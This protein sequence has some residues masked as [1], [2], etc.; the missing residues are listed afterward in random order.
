MANMGR[1][2]KPTE[3]KRLLGNPGRRPLPNTGE[4]VIIPGANEPPEPARQ[5]FEYGRQ[6]W[7]RVWRAGAPWI[8]PDFDVELLLIVCEQ[9]D[10]RIRLRANVWNN[11]RAD[12][13]RALRQLEAQI[14]DNLSKLG[15]SPTDRARLG[16]AE[17]KIQSKMQALQEMKAA[18]LNG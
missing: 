9:T 4:L 8:S 14:V 16:V 10:E 11:N 3:Q 1:P 2:P 7:D 5:L 6:L 13:R 18:R 15:F 12:E 17:V